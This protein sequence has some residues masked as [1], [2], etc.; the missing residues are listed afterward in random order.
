MLETY[1]MTIIPLAPIHVGTGEC[2]S[3]GEYFVFDDMIYAVNL[4]A[5]PYEEMGELRESLIKWI[6]GNPI[7]WVLNVNNSEKL[8]NLICKHA[9]FKCKTTSNVLKAINARWGT[10]QSQLEISLIHR[11]MKSAMIPGSSIKGAI[12]TALLWDRIGGDLKSIPGDREVDK[13]ERRQ[14]APN[15]GPDV[16]KIENDLLCALKITDATANCNTTFVLQPTHIGMSDSTSAEQLQDYRECLAKANLERPYTI[17]GTLTID[18]SRLEFKNMVGLL[19]QDGILKSCRSFYNEV[20]RVEQ[21][22][23]KDGTQESDKNALRVCSEIEQYASSIADGSL[24]RLGWGSGM[25]A[26]GLNLAKP[27]GNHPP[28]AINPQYFYKSKTRVLI[29][30]FPPGWGLLRLV[31]I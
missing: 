11:T 30:G 23:W 10:A 4:G 3:P 8:K 6:D 17:S 14:L 5:I 16:E 7:T 12:R 31:R 2:M 19:S 20:M 26:V 15:S 27:D 13:W 9:Q 18:T 21:N 22:Y 28:R 24:I 29:A 1:K 25:N